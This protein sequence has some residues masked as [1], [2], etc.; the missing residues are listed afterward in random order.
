MAGAL[1]ASAWLVILGQFWRVTDYPLSLTWSEGN[2]LWASSLFLSPGRYEFAY[3]LV[4]P[5]YVTPGL[6]TL[7]GLP[8]LISSMS[9]V[10]MRVWESLLW[11]WPG[12]LFGWALAKRY[13][14]SRPA[15]AAVV[16]FW[17]YLFLNQGPVYAPLLIAGAITIWG[18]GLKREGFRLT[19]IFLAT[20]LAGLSRWTWTPAPALWAALMLVLESRWPSVDESKAWPIRSILISVVAGLA[21]G[22]LSQWIS[23]QITG[24][25]AMMYLNAMEHPLL[26]YRLAPNATYVAGVVGAAILAVRPVLALVIWLSTSLH[27]KLR[28]ID[29][30]LVGGVL[31]VFLAG[32]LVVSVKIGGGNNLHNMDV[33]LVTLVFV[34]G[35]FVYLA[36]PQDRE[37]DRLSAGLLLWAALAP[38]IWGAYAY[39]PVPEWPVATAEHIV[40]EINSWMDIKAEEGE[41]LF[42]DQRHLLTLGLSPSYPFVSEYELV[43]MMDHAM[44]SDQSYFESFYADLERERFSLI[45]SDPMNVF[46]KGRHESFG[47]ENDAWVRFVSQ[48]ILEMYQ[49]I[50]RWDDMGVWLLAPIGR[51]D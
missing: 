27:R 47:E 35:L 49:P 20:L 40:A 17:T 50:A 37:W 24:R 13:F 43:E 16:M 22:A 12:L 6:Y 29:I 44:A 5:N 30:G 45:I 32:G 2:H 11:V 15:L 3:D 31:G 10:W 18:M 9:L 26:W 41:I 33:F 23:A 28:A 21:A 42:I 19:A 4:V 1:G 14:H 39:Q 7:R 8:L 25:P 38:A 48:P 46:W 51:S 36:R 34:A